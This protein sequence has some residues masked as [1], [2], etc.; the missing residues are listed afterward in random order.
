MSTDKNIWRPPWGPIKLGPIH[1][2]K[3][4]NRKAWEIL[5]KAVPLD[6]KKAMPPQPSS[7]WRSSQLSKRQWRQPGLSRFKTKTSL[8]LSWMHCGK[9][10][11][12]QAELMRN[13]TGSGSAPRAISTHLSKIGPAQCPSCKTS[14]HSHLNFLSKEHTLLW[15]SLYCISFCGAYYNWESILFIGFRKLF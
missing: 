13:C 5:D 14:N 2:G 4:S 8:G 11:R 10:M 3:Q 7:L 12:N 9:L 15:I 1:I 6:L